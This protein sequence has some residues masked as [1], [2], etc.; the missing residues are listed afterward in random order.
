MTVLSAMF[1]N[2]RV[3]SRNSRST[4]TLLR[5]NDRSHLLKKLLMALKQL[6]NKSRN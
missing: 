3:L 1:D 5:N 4:V 6:Q 2:C